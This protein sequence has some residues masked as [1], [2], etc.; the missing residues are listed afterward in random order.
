MT[1][2]Q[3]NN[4]VDRVNNGGEGKGGRGKGHKGGYKNRSNSNSNSFIYLIQSS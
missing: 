4:D 2:V 1:N 3:V